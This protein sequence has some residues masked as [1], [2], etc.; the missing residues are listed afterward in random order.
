[1]VTKGAAMPLLKMTEFENMRDTDFCDGCGGYVRADAKVT[2]TESGAAVH[3]DGCRSGNVRRRRA[4][5]VRTD[6]R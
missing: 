3:C 5:G 6:G 2:I 1:M 4:Q